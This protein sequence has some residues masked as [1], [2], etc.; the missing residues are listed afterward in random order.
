MCE[1]LGTEPVDSEIPV[2]YEDFPIEI[3]EVFQVYKLL[4]DNWDYFNGTYIGKSLHSIKD[5]L[6]ICN[7]PED[8]SIFFI[9]T[10]ALLDSFRREEYAQHRKAAS[11][12]KI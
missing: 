5:I 2:E 7:V 10:I 8:Q 3:Q 4:Q 11:A 9:E 12:S 1:M 6:K